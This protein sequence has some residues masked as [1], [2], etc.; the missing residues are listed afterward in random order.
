MAITEPPPA[1]VL[2]LQSHPQWVVWRSVHRKDEPKPTKVPYRAAQPSREAKSTDPATWG[3]Y[4]EAR[5]VADRGRADG[6]GYVF[7][8]DR[9]IAGVDLDNCLDL[10]TG[11]IHPAALDIIRRLN[12]YTE[13]SPSGK[14]VHIYVRGVVGGK[15]VRKKTKKTPWGGDFESYDRERFFTFTGRHLPGTPTTIEERHDELAAIRAEMFPQPKKRESSVPVNG[16]VQGAPRDDVALLDKARG[17]KNGAAFIA[18][19]DQGDTGTHG[20]DDSA[21]DLALC[22]LLAFYTGPD[23]ARIDSLFRR[24]ALYR[25]K[26]DEMRGGG[27]YGQNTIEKA[28]ED[29]T[30]FYGSR[31]GQSRPLFQGRVEAEQGAR[32][33]L[34]ELL[35]L[36]DLKIVGGTRSAH[37]TRARVI[38][39]LSDES[40][41]DLNPISSYTTAAKLGAEVAMQLG[42]TPDL[43]GKVPTVLAL[44]R[45]ICELREEVTVDNRARDFGLTF[46]QEAMLYVVDMSNQLDRWRAFRKIA[47]TNPGAEAKAE[48][49]SIAGASIV[50]HDE[51]RRLRFVRAQWFYDHVRGKSSPGVADD[52]VRRMGLLGW[53]KPGREGRIKATQPDGSGSLQWAFY[54]VPDG[55]ENA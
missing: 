18:L 43:K 23:P 21:A 47:D 3:S 17:A 42:C 35:C 38:L 36:G 11:E 15:R 39:R 19:Y 14:G 32:A 27:T 31:N 9:G 5:D 12:S 37:D 30:E 22:N 29:R 26:W 40:V 44:M 53:E 51:N 28:L 50:L 10:E 33:E 8:P 25:D 7:A 2:E 1:A 41:L 54:M 48:S 24:S 45:T 6:P 16:T 34:A 20:G 4:D 13:I 49:T 46:L 52:V 55:W